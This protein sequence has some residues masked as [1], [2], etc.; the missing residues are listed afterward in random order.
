[1]GES[2]AELILENILGASHE[3]GEPQSRIEVLLMELLEELSGG[4]GGKKLYQHNVNFSVKQNSITLD[5]SSVYATIITDSAEPFTDASLYSYFDSI[6]PTEA[7]TTT[8]FPCGGHIR[9][10]STNYNDPVILLN[11]GSA[12]DKISIKVAGSSDTHTYSIENTSTSKF[13]VLYDK[14]TEL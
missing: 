4:G 12:A 13:F 9:V 5:S 1:M 10:S 3:L 2:R 11:S 7:A 8:G 14:V 6:R